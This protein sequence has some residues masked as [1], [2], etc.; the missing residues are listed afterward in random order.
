MKEKIIRRIFAF[1]SFIFTV[2]IFNMESEI[3]STAVKANQNKEIEFNK[4]NYGANLKDFIKKVNSLPIDERKKIKNDLKENNLKSYNKL[5]SK[6]NSILIADDIVKNKINNYFEQAADISPN[7]NLAL[8]AYQT[9]TALLLIL[10]DITNI[11]YKIIHCEGLTLSETKIVKFSHKFALICYDHALILFDFEDLNEVKTKLLKTHKSAV[12]KIDINNDLAISASDSMAILWDLSNLKEIKSKQLI[13]TNLISSI[14]LSCDNKFALIATSNGILLFNLSNLE[15][16][17]SK[18]LSK[19]QFYSKHLYF[20]NDNKF[21]VISNFFHAIIINRNNLDT[22]T[23][24]KYPDLVSCIK[25]NPYIITG[26]ENGNLRIYTRSLEKYEE[27]KEH[28]TKINDLQ[29]DNSGTVVLSRSEDGEAIL[30]NIKK[31]E[32]YIKLKKSG[33]RINTIALSYNAKFALTINKAGKV[34]LWILSNKI[35]LDQLILFKTL[36]ELSKKQIDSNFIFEDHFFRVIFNNFNPEQ[37]K[38][39]IEKFNLRFI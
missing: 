25:I 33:E 35:S 6:L 21:I 20:S 28:K 9:N 37:Q 10:N 24:I 5:K 23:L 3:S 27:F 26:S 1:I 8:V 22:Y 17:E 39:L 34:R 38:Y 32:N 36:K 16:I 29:L 19:K 18:L 14:A 15:N 4:K 31:K 11:K 12:K 7:E 30:W 2:P 13:E